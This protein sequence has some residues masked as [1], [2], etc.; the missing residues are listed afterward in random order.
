MSK[1]LPCNSMD[2]SHDPAFPVLVLGEHRQVLGL[3]QASRF[4][5]L[6]QVCSRINLGDGTCVPQQNSGLAP[7]CLNPGSR[8][9]RRATPAQ[10]VVQRNRLW[11]I[12]RIGRQRALQWKG[13][14]RQCRSR[15]VRCRIVIS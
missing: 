12:P 5:L 6:K 4:V 13:L 14:G 8:Y 7:I 1:H 2:V 15:E 3:G 10:R 9:L 11:P